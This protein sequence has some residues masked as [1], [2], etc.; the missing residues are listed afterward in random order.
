M[1]VESES[2]QGGIGKSKISHM[3]QSQTSY[4]TAIWESN[5]YVTF[6]PGICFGTAAPT[7]AAQEKLRSLWLQGEIRVVKGRNV[8]DEQQA[9]IHLSQSL[10]ILLSVPW[11]WWV[12]L[13]RPPTP[14]L[15]DG[16]LS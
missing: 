10:L 13:P 11:N 2:I 3:L 1:W 12:Q 8:I 5:Y 16:S 7:S 9:E 15:F 4:P 14:G 6:K